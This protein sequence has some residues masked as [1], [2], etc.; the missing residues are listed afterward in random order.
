MKTSTSTAKRYLDKDDGQQQ[1]EAVLG[2]TV[3]LYWAPAPLCVGEQH[4]LP[5]PSLL[6]LRHRGTQGRVGGRGEHVKGEDFGT[7][8]RWGPCDGPCLSQH[9]GQLLASLLQ[10]LVLVFDAYDGA[11]G[12]G[13]AGQAGGRVISGLLILLSFNL[14]PSVH[15]LVH[16]P[17]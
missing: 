17:L 11:Q 3:L 7:G 14:H 10:G 16:L 9:Q 2:S 6:P 15:L 13:E 8:S 1:V 12:R 5:P 4:S